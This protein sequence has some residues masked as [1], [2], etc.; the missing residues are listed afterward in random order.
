MFK[1]LND[2]KCLISLVSA[3]AVLVSSFFG[4][5]CQAGP[6]GEAPM[7]GRL[8]EQGKLPPVEQRLPERPAVVQP[9]ERIG[10]YGGQMRTITGSP[11]N[12]TE[13]QYMVFEPLL[14]FA[15]DGVTIVPNVV[16][17]WQIGEDGKSITLF[18][19]KGMRW[20]DG[21]PVTVEDVLFSWYDVI[22]NKD[23]YPNPPTMFKVGSK[24]MEIERVDDFTF[25]LV[26]AEPYPTICYSLTRIAAAPA[27]IDVLNLLIQP[28]HYLRKYHPKYTAL[29][30]IEDKAKQAG[31][32]NWFELFREIN[33]PARPT[34]MLSPQT[35]PDF[36]TIGPWHVVEV[37]AT[38]HTILQR[39]PY[40]WKVDPE[41]NQLPYIDR[42]HST[43]IGNPEARNLQFVT[44]DVDFAGLY[45]RLENT[46]LFLS[47]RQKAGYSVYFW[48]ENQGS[49]VS[50]Y[51]NQTHRDPVLRKIFQDRRFRIALSLAID[52]QEI[53]E[54]VY[55]G[56]C[57]PQQDTVNRICSFFEP[58]FE[59]SY[60][61]YDPD[62]ANRILDEIGL[63][64]RGVKGWRYRLDGRQLAIVLDA[65][66]VEPYKKTAQLLKE[67]W[68]DVGVLLNWRVVENNL[69]I[70]RLM[71]NSADVIGFPND[72][73]TDISV[74][75]QPLLGIAIWAPLW[76]RW[77]TMQGE[78]GEE[79]PQQIK[80]L[81]K[82]WEELRRTADPQDRIIL[83]K[84]LVRSQ[85]ENLWGIGTVG[86][87][88]RP[89][90][91]SNRL[92]NVPQFMKDKDGNLLEGERALWGWPWLA[93]FLHHP[94]QFYI[95]E[96]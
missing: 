71:G 79:P 36:P 53:N 73:A 96:D 86:E 38:G 76:D 6:Y 84:K 59:T 33:Y 49:R 85:A 26:F 19:R 68:Q 93:T 8:V 57:K 66:D 94:E 65:I 63:E 17:H 88:I 82:L 12:L 78:Q 37:P 51:F 58:E 77:L 35:P 62:R 2:R 67:Y 15:S 39:N 4:G 28:K 72:V 47:N 18:L 34:G 54:V 90:I 9:Y 13:A 40:Y 20:S 70:L 92:H 81:Y 5:R 11:D 91:V 16:T 69:M 56:K 42:I 29:R 14:R 41:G 89:I 10:V 48:R 44:G 27:G 32:A 25:R 61:E 50:Y 3:T 30:E 31:F 45:S 87:S 22:L 74:L 80:E 7:L 64:R 95:K 60:A 46:P 75:S 23:I 21:V 55:F 1:K 24:P 83:G 52:R 43:Y